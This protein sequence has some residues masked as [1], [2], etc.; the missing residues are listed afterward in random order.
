MIL[1]ENST[2]LHSHTYKTVDGNGFTIRGVTITFW[3]DN[4]G[5]IR[6]RVYSLDELSEEV[7]V[8]YNICLAAQ[9]TFDAAMNKV[10]KKKEKGKK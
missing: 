3:D 6:E 8:L 5:E 10:I 2:F 1:P 7:K 4:R 9:E